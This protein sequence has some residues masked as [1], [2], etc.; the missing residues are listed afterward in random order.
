MLTCFRY[1][2]AFVCFAAGV[3]CLAL[4]GRGLQSPWCTDVVFHYPT[5]SGQC[6]LGQGRLSVRYYSLDP[7][8]VG[9]APAQ[10]FSVNQYYLVGESQMLAGNVTDRREFEK[11]GQFGRIHHAVYFPLWYP[12]LLFALAGVAALRLGRRFTLRSVIIATSLLAGL[13]GMAVAL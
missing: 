13:L 4:W 10:R 11:R 6:T 7:F 2:L 3:G 9:L 5:L 1:A 12:A 8:P